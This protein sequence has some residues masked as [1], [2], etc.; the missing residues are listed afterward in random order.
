L[1]HAVLFVRDAL[2]LRPEP[3]L[4][5]PPGLRD[6]VPDRSELLEPSAR[7]AAAR[8]WTT[9]WATVVELESRRHSSN[10]DQDALARRERLLE[11]DRAINP[12][13]SPALS[14]ALVRPA[15]ETLFGEACSWDGT[16][17]L[18]NARDVTSR[19]TTFAWEVVR[20]TAEAVAAAHHVDV[21]AIDGAAS[22]LLVEGV[23]W[24]LVARFALCSLAAADD[25]NVAGAMLHSVFESGLIAT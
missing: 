22:I 5:V 11:Y 25:P 10:S 2:G 4:G 13:T 12:A 18:P 1:P 8:E 17:D 23:W 20:D 3:T 15:A 9:W 21:G 19:R 16:V 14:D 7:A 24:D 6:K